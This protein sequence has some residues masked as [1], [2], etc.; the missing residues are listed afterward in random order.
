[1]LISKLIAFR[2]I[3]LTSHCDKNKIINVPRLQ[4]VASYFIYF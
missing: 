3:H 4:A 1:M 2:S